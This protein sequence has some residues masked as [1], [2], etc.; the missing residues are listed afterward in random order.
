MPYCRDCGCQFNSSTNIYCGDCANEIVSRSQRRVRD[1]DVDERRRM[2]NDREYAHSWLQSVIGWIVGLM[3]LISKI[4]TG[5]CFLTSAVAAFKGL[6]DGGPEMTLLR[7]FREDYIFRSQSSRRQ[8]DLD[9]YYLV[10]SILRRWI[11]S[12]ADYEDIWEYV[13]NYVD[14]VLALLRG[15]R[16]TMAYRQFKLR[17]LALRWDVLGGLHNARPARPSGHCPTI[18]SMRTRAKA[19]RAG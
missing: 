8:R 1:A 18:R 13:W 7:Q 4:F 15:R 12:R 16:Y 19:A 6:D 14:E 10:G 9:E 2:N 5:D 3:P 17:T 11:G